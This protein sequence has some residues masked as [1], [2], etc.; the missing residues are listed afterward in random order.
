MGRSGE[1]EGSLGKAAL[2]PLLV[3]QDWKGSAPAG[4]GGDWDVFAGAGINQLH[5]R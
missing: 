3:G 1:D 4:F 2:G 5:Y